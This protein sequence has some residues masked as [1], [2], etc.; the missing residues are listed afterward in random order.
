MSETSTK[1]FSVL[2]IGAVCL[3][4]YVLLFGFYPRY[5]DLQWSEEV[6]QPNGTVAVV[7]VKNTYERRGTRFKEYDEN[8]I[9]FRRKDIAFDSES[10]Q[11]KILST[12][13]PIAYLGKFDRDWYAVVSGKGPY[14]NFSDEM[15]TRWGEDFTTLGQRLAIW[16]D[17][18]FVPIPWELAPQELVKMNLIESAFFVEFVEW[19]GKRLSLEKKEAFNATHETPYRQKVTR[20]A[21]FSKNSGEEK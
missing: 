9:T 2:A 1:I 4:G 14:G 3:V 6:L 8:S 7:K 12:R 21:K 16:R 19:N 13:M 5:F 20:P 18:S 10:G 11:E 15:P 17:G